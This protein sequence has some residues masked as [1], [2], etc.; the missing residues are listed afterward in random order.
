MRQILEK[1]AKL[2]R[3]QAYGLQA[4][5]LISLRESTSVACQHS[6]YGFSDIPEEIVE[7]CDALDQN[8]QL[9]VVIEIC[10]SFLDE[11][12]VELDLLKTA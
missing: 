9:V 8:A 3:H 7:L 11:D 2:D 12:F 6:E 1:V 5:I 10:S 4:L